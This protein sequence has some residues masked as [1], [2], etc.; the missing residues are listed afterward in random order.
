MSAGRLCSRR[1]RCRTSS[2]SEWNR[3]RT[4]LSVSLVVAA[5]LLTSDGDW[6]RFTTFVPQRETCRR[7]GSRELESC[8]ERSIHL[9]YRHPEHGFSGT[10]SGPT[11]DEVNRR[12]GE[13]ALIYRAPPLLC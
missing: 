13:G 11:A 9:T 12:R 4:P 6:P 1:A 5:G 2:N 10:R 8:S 3:V 7:R